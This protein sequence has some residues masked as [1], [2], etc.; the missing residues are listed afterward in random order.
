MPK[1]PLM[2]KVRIPEYTHP[3]NTWREAI[4]EAVS[5]AQAR[6]GVEYQPGDRLEVNSSALLY[7][8]AYCRDSR[9]RQSSQ[10]LSGRVAGPSGGTK[11][12][13]RRRRVPIVP[14]DRQIWRVVVEKALAPKQAL[15]RGRLTIRRV[16]RA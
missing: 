6:A 11:T 7:R 14:N 1:R 9:R 4:H 10:G 13:A 8:R 12:K 3:R 15:G 16:R 2:L 5:D